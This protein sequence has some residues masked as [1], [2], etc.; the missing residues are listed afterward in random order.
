MRSR[1]VPVWSVNVLLVIVQPECAA[2]DGTLSKPGFDDVTEMVFPVTVSSVVGAVLT[3]IPFVAVLPALT[4]VMTLL[5]IV[6]SVV[7][8]VPLI[9]NAEA[10]CA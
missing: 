2:A 8:T 1:F 7:V 4:V 9:S 3:L 5:L 6:T 10:I